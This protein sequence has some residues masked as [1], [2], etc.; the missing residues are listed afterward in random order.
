VKQLLQLPYVKS[1]DA[2]FLRHLINHVPSNMNAIQV[3]ALHTSMQDLILDH[4]LLSVLDSETNKDWELQ[5]AR[6]RD[7]PSMS[8]VTYFLEDGTRLSYFKPT[9]LRVLRQ[10]NLHKRELRSVSHHGA[11]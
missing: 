8:A 9:S 2:T 4:L 1:N 7:I 3:L 11:I 6:Q 10:K 5:T